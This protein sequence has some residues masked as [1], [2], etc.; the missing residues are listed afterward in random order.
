MEIVFPAQFY[1]LLIIKNLIKAFLSF[2]LL[3]LSLSLYSFF[4]FQ[5]E[6]FNF[7]KFNIFQFGFCTKWEYFW[8]LEKNFGVWIL[9]LRNFGKFVFVCSKISHQPIGFGNNRSIGF[10]N[11][12]PIGFENDRSI[13]FRNE[14][15]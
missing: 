2:H 5:R 11:D 8:I 12:Q 10:E 3:N 15:F 6:A 1:I 14:A 13:G 4:F 7:Y 9:S